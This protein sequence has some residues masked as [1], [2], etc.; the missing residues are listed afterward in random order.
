MER[1]HHP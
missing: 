1:N